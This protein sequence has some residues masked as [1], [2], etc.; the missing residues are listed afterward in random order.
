MC[1]VAESAHSINGELL[2]RTRCRLQLLQKY[3]RQRFIPVLVMR[4]RET[5]LLSAH[6]VPMK[7]A[8]MEWTG[9]HVVRDLERLRHHERPCD[10]EAALKNLVS[11]VSRIRGDAVTISEHSAVGDS[12]GNDLIECAVR[13]VER[14]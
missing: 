7:G 4:D 11:E 5:R 1:L 3:V 6:A 9:Q 2:E 13:T 14:S 10:G 12:Q 8:V